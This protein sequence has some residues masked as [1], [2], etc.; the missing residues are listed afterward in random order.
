[1]L[2][3]G[4]DPGGAIECALDRAEQE[5]AEASLPGE[6]AGHEA[7]ERDGDQRDQ[8][9]VD[10]EEKSETAESKVV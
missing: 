5:A 3:G 2:A 8:P 1:M 6:D 4:I 10:E 9:E 7:S